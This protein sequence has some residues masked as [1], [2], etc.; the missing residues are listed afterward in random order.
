[1]MQMLLV[2]YSRVPNTYPLS[3][4]LVIRI[5]FVESGKDACF[6]FLCTIKIAVVWF[7]C[8]VHRFR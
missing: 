1:M 4:F 6:F 3:S 2:R 8:Y 5:F 7:N